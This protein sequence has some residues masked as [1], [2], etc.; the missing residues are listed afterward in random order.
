VALT[1]A[2]YEELLDVLREVPV[3]VDRL[4]ARHAGFDEDV[5][6]WLKRAE[7]TL[8]NNRL[9]AASQIA[10]YRARL[11]EAGRGVLRGDL[12]I[13]GRTSVRKIKEA[14]AALQLELGNDVLQAAIAERQSVFQEAERIARQ[15]MAVAR[16]KGIGM[17][18]D[19][20]GTQQRF[21]HELRDRLS[22]DPDLAS[23]YTHI[24]G[25][26][27]PTDTLVMLD[28]AATSVASKTEAHH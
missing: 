21:L 3:L 13:V 6:R 27:G 11:I 17:P 22:M 16:A 7:Q 5:L 28:R 24:V 9:P 12:T 14:T 19:D 25:L 18:P 23:V 15:V 1:V 2:Q 20:S 26:V 4:E 10:S 8:T